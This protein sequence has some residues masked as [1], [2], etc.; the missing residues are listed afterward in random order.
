MRGLKVAVLLGALMATTGAAAQTNDVF[1][2]GLENLR[3]K[4]SYAEA[5]AQLS[6]SIPAMSGS[7]RGAPHTNQAE[8]F[9]GPVH[10]NDCTLEIWTFFA[11][12]QLDHV[13]V[14]PQLGPVTD[15]CRMAIE[16]ELVAHYGE[17]ARQ[18]DITPP[19]RRTKIG[20]SMSWKTPTTTASYTS[21]FGG[22]VSLQEAGG[23]GLTFYDFIGSP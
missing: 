15:A 5:K 18:D 13:Y 17:T 3:W 1:P 7:T 21:S 8:Y 22:Q 11:K 10:W 2:F 16:D 19:P 4:M 6:L 9:W 12:D 14:M 20:I 23:P